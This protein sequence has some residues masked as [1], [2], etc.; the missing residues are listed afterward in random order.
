MPYPAARH[1]RAAGEPMNNLLPKLGTVCGHQCFSWCNISVGVVGAAMSGVK[2]RRYFSIEMWCAEAAASLTESARA[3][4]ARSH[5]S[6]ARRASGEVEGRVQDALRHRPRQRFTRPGRVLLHVTVWCR[7]QREFFRHRQPLTATG[8]GAPGSFVVPEAYYT[9]GVSP[10]THRANGTPP[11]ICT[12]PL[13]AWLTLPSSSF[14]SSPP[15]HLT[16][17]I[18]SSAS[19]SVFCELAL[20]CQVFLRIF[21]RSG[22]DGCGCP[23]PQ[24]VRSPS[25]AHPQT[26]LQ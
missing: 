15:L 10:I 2:V 8:Y 7:N 5:P 25:P 16:S 14:L 20:I 18:L 13:D 26:R 9:N 3:A 23:T 22:P 12:F 1:S 24:S 21:P 17:T 11:Y 19:S 4:C 6:V